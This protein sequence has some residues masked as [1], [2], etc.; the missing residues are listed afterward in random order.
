MSEDT[1]PADREHTGWTTAPSL[2]A[3]ISANESAAW[4]RFNRLYTV[5]LHYWFRRAGVAE[6]EWPD[7]TNEVFLAVVRGLPGFR[8]GGERGAFRGWLRVIG[9]NKVADLCRDRVPTPADPRAR[10]GARARVA[11]RGR[12]AEPVGV[13]RAR[14]GEHGLRTGHAARVP[15]DGAR[16]AHGR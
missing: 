15:T 16:R 3:G 12:R 8:H 4:E 13:P 7:L 1:D 2:I 11:R 9:R 6:G 10:R 14:T 5:L